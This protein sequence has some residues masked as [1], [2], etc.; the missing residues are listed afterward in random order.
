MI[1]TTCAGCSFATLDGFT[2]DQLDCSAGI[3][4]KFKDQDVKLE[5]DDNEQWII[6]KGR[7]CPYRNYE[8]LSVDEAAE[9]MR[10]HIN[11]VIKDETSKEDVI[12]T[13]ESIQALNLKKYKII[14]VSDKYG[15]LYKDYYEYCKSQ[16]FKFNII[17]LLEDTSIIN[18]VKRRIDNGF[19]YLLK[20]GDIAS[21]EALEKLHKLLNVDL[22]KVIILKHLDTYIL[23]SI[24]LYTFGDNLFNVCGPEFTYDSSNL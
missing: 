5:M 17:K 24:A 23:Q 16:N 18:Q 15:G 4:K 8:N 12:K 9:K 1:D 19:T 7:M 11:F 21:S 3:L 14:I 13:I 20:S 6:I 10:P 22:K 2:G